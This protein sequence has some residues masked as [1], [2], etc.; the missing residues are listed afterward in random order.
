MQK[1]DGTLLRHRN[2]VYCQGHYGLDLRGICSYN[3]NLINCLFSHM[4]YI[5]CRLIGWIE[6]DDSYGYLIS[7]AQNGHSFA[8]KICRCIFLNKHFCLLVKISLNFILKGLIDNNQA[9]VQIMA[10]CLIGYKPLSEPM[11]TWFT[12]IYIYGT[13]GRWVYGTFP[14]VTQYS[15]TCL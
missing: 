14:Y 4:K 2:N 5:R 3:W 1:N 13:R 7:L 10:W 6:D 15:E 12:D 11:L 8:D 9:L